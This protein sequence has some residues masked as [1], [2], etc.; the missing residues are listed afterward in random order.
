MKAIKKFFKETWAFLVLVA[1]I[2]VYIIVNQKRPTAKEIDDKKEEIKK[3]NG[4][5]DNQQDS[6]NQAESDLKQTIKSGKEK[7]D[8][9][10]KD[11]EDRDK[12]ANPY[13]P[14]L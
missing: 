8:Q 14:D 4:L 12:K 11:K 2:I 6:V 13:F 9:I 3:Q 1:A 10:K 5:V 7:T